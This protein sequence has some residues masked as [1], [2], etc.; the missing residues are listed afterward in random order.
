LEIRHDLDLRAISDSTMVAELET[1]VQLGV[2]QGQEQFEAAALRLILSC[3]DDPATCWNAFYANSLA[4]LQ[5]GR[6]PF[7]PVHRR[8]LSLISGTSVLEV[9]SCFGLFALTC[10]GTG[11]DVHAC[12][13]SRGAVRLLTDASAHLGLDV[14]ARVGDALALPYPD[15]FV[16]TVTLIHL[17]EH[18][19]GRVDHAI[20][21][22]L[23]VARRRVV[24]AVPYE[25][26]ASAHFG[27]HTVLTPASL[28][29]WAA[30]ARHAGA[31]VS[32]DHGGW[33]VLQAPPKR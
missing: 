29:S 7:A 8:A 6:S 15:D 27:H 16:D 2:L 17:L 3:A 11:L 5:S 32:T 33:L 26:V 30:Q 10:A 20:A 23:R 4:E 21:E 14:N 22:A 28:T 24:I 13:I 19:P 12:D 31:T 25:E 9:G 1:L 18:L